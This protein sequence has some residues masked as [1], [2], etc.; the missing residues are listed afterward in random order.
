[1]TEPSLQSADPT[2]L[3]LPARV[4]LILAASVV[5][6]GMTPC[7]GLLQWP[8]LVLCVP[9]VVLGSLG[10]RRARAA[11]PAQGLS[12]AP[13]LGALVGGVLLL[14]LAATRLVLGLGVA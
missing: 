2:G 3:L 1:M 5:M 7:L 4:T 10:L 6:V 11:P 8:G 14:V 13:F 9:P 12:A